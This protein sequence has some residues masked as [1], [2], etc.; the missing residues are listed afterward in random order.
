MTEVFV[1]IKG[2]GIGGCDI[3]LQPGEENDNDCTCLWGTVDYAFCAYN[4]PMN[5][6]TTI[7]ND[8][9]VQKGSCPDVSGETKLCN[10]LSDLGNCY[11]NGYTCIISI[12]GKCDCHH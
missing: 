5:D 4:K 2:S 7:N 6:N 11:R 8:I 9:D 10:D 1:K 12:D 3:F